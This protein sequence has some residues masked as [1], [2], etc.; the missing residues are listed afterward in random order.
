MSAGTAKT[1][2]CVAQSVERLDYGHD[3]PGREVRFPEE[4][5]DFSLLH[6]DQMVSVAH[7]ASYPVG[8]E[9][10]FPGGKAAR[11]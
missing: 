4:A 6:T 11:A 1:T 10:C 2:V 9:G 7:P 3:G 5:R 8:T